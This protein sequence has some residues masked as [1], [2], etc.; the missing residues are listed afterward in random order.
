MKSQTNRR[1]FGFFLPYYYVFLTF[2][3]NFSICQKLQVSPIFSANLER[4]VPIFINVPGEVP[5][6]FTNTTLKIS[7]R[8]EK[9]H[10]QIL[11]SSRSRRTEADEEETTSLLSSSVAGKLIQLIR[12][13]K[14]ICRIDVSNKSF[15]QK[16]HQKCK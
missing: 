3:G 4:T 11:A 10:S 16:Y 14:Q 7:S 15:M 1:R 13:P 5:D 9:W 12:V 2:L 8:L 6:A